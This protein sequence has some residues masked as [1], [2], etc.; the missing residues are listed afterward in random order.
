VG[1]TASGVAHA[2]CLEI[3]MKFDIAATSSNN[4]WFI[5]QTRFSTLL[6]NFDQTF[7]GRMIL[8]PNK[9]WPDL[10]TVDPVDV[11]QMMLEVAEIG[12]QVKR[13]FNADRMNY[14]SL[15]NV[16]EQL[17]WHIIPRYDGDVNWGGPPWPVTAP[18]NPSN[19][20]RQ[21]TIARIRAALTCLD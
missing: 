7:I 19:E 17:H 16:V 20:E 11:S 9:E 6:L 18:R 1:D 3:F 21:E 15:G 8:V 2:W 14:A 12:G 13:A 10:E 5:G 4:P